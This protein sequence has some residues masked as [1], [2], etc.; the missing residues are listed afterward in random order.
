MSIIS[1]A[2]ADRADVFSQDWA[3]CLSTLVPD[4]MII[5]VAIS[6]SRTMIR[7]EVCSMCIISC[8]LADQADV[9]SQDWAC[10]LPKRAT[11]QMVIAVAMRTSRT[12]R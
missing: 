8:A 1:S 2:Q 3:C 6:A 12:M 4:Q 11:D 5:A 9:I 10:R 7:T